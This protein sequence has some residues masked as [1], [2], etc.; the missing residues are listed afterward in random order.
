MNKKLTDY[1]IDLVEILNKQQKQVFWGIF[2]IL[3]MVV[4]IIV[5]YILFYGLINPAPVDYV[6]YTLLAFLLYQ[7]MIAFWGLNA[8]IHENLFRSDAQ[9]CSFL[10]N[11]LCLP[12]IVFYPFHRTLH[13][14]E[15]LP[16][17]ASSYHL[18]VDLF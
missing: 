16:Y 12:S 8:S 18:A 1:V 14:V 10:W 3:S 13:F 4:S 5:S 6:I 11:L 15:Y 7:I 2:D 17:L 9:Q